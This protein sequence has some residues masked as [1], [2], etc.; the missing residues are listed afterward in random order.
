M[1]LSRGATIGY[2]AQHQ[3]LEDEHTIYEALLEVKKDV[4][5]MEER[6]RSLELQMKSASGGE[7]ESMLA[8]YSRLNH[9][10]EMLKAMPAKV[11]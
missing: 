5:L 8:E 6:L 1:A 7:L 10:F 4:L 11:R 2:L 3:D 9:A